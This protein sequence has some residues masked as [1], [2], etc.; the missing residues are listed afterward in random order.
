MRDLAKNPRPA[1]RWP[2]GSSRRPAA[3]GSASTNFAFSGR[4]DIA[5]G[6]NRNV[7]AGFNRGDGVVFRLA[8][9]T[10]GAGTAVNR[11]RLDAGILRQFENIQW[12]FC[13]R[14]VPAGANLQRYRH[15]HRLH[16]ARQD[17]RHQ[18]LVLQ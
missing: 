12:R 1:L 3:G 5:V 18:R 2:T 16:H 13:D 9:I 4:G 10:A 14:T 11:Q 6:D 8:R 17:L 15:L 7:R